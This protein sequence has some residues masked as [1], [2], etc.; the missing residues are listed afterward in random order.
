MGTISATKMLLA[1]Q[2]ATLAVLFTVSA[3]CADTLV[4]RRRCQHHQEPRRVSSAPTSGIPP[5]K[6]AEVQLLLQQRNPST[7]K[8][9]SDV[10][11]EKHDRAFKGTVIV[12]LSL[13]PSGGQSKAAE[14][15]VIGGTMTD[16]E[17]TDC[18]VDKLKDF[19]Y[20]GILGQGHDAA[21]R[22]E[23]GTRPL[24]YQG[25]ALPLSYVGP[26]VT[27]GSKGWWAGRELNP[28]SRRRLIYSQRSSPPAQPTHGLRLPSE[29]RCLVVKRMTCAAS[30]SVG[31]DDGTRTRNRRFTK[32]LLYQLSYVGGDVEGYR[33]HAKACN[34]VPGPCSALGPRHAQRSGFWRVRLDQRVRRRCPPAHVFAPSSDGDRHLS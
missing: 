32:P 16:K 20:P 26:A 19:D 1:A 27:T 5:D 14:V 6:E 18:V 10:L 25:S 13:E 12:L 3:G 29:T 28:H 21:I 23:P 2:L 8:C 7:L 9:Y 31:A 15:K 11:N 24:P 30:S 17:V 22:T 4:V 33:T 34:G